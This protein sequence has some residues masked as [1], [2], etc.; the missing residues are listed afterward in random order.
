MNDDPSR[1]IEPTPCNF[2]LVVQPD[3]RHKEYVVHVHQQALKSRQSR[4]PF[5]TNNRSPFLCCPFSD[6]PVP[7]DLRIPLVGSG[8]RSRSRQMKFSCASCPFRRGRLCKHPANSRGWV[9][10]PQ[11]WRL[12]VRTLSNR[13]YPKPP[14]WC[15]RRPA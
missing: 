4:T 14:A 5:S 10:S 13:F 7:G 8:S 11:G 3:F 6:L 12:T 2:P 9:K 1:T 15:K